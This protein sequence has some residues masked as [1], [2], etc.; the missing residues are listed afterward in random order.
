LAALRVDGDG[1]SEISRIVEAVRSGGTNEAV[2]AIATD[3]LKTN[4]KP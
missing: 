1:K 2:L 3:V 4:I